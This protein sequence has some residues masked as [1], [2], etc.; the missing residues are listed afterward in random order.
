VREHLAAHDWLDPL[1]L[2]TSAE[3]LAEAW[4]AIEW[5]AGLD[6]EEMVHREPDGA[7]FRYNAN[8]PRIIQIETV[9]RIVAE[10]GGLVT[11]TEAA[12]AADR[13]WRGE[14][15]SLGGV[16][17]VPTIEHVAKIGV[18]MRV[19]RFTAEPPRRMH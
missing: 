17:G 11:R 1:A 5:Y 9:Q 12:R 15:A 19:W 16:L 10:M 7:G 4:R 2:A 6:W 14:N 13:L 8:V 18:E 3:H